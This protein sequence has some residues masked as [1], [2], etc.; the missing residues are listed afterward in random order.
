MPKVGGSLKTHGGEHDG[1]AYALVTMRIR[2][3]SEPE[4]FELVQS[5]ESGRAG[6]FLR[7]ALET[8]VRVGALSLAGY[9][10]LRDEQLRVL[11]VQLQIER[12][13]RRQLEAQLSHLRSV[14]DLFNHGGNPPDLPEPAVGGV[15]SAEDGGKEGAS[16][17]VA[18]SPPT[19]ATVADPPNPTAPA[20]AGAATEPSAA[21]QRHGGVSRFVSSV[22]SMQPEVKQP[23]E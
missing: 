17:P 5:I 1:R 18:P 23:G 13:Q 7:S 20:N 12:D 6:S 15:V 14:Q 3:Y 11:E 2:R 19:A 9:V 4:L 8:A 10:P 16:E 22:L 21:G